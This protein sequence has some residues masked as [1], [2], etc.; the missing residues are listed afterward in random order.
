MTRHQQKIT[1]FVSNNNNNPTTA[2][3]EIIAKQIEG[4]KRMIWVHGDPFQEE[5]DDDDDEKAQGTIQ[6]NPAMK[7]HWELEIK[8]LREAPRDRDKLRKLVKAKQKEWED[9]IKIEDL[10]R[11][12]TEMEMLRFV[13]FAVIRGSKATEERE[14]NDNSSIMNAQR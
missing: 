14:K 12:V 7:R 8:I 4:I 13:L 5:N 6:I 1:T 9:T 10:E 11:I 3:E 2:A